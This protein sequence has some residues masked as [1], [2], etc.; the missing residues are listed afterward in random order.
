MNLDDSQM[1]ALV[2]S[3][4]SGRVELWLAPRE[5]FLF[6]WV[7]AGA[8]LAFLAS[9]ACYS[10]LPV[11]RKGRGWLARCHAPAIDIERFG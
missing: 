3:D 7:A 2:P 1:L 11:R 8:A 4:G 5:F 9:L 6:A 10:L